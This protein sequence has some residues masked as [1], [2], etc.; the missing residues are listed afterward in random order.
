MVTVSRIVYKQY[1]CF[2]NDYTQNF[3]ILENPKV[4]KQ[5]KNVVKNGV[6]LRIPNDK[7]KRVKWHTFPALTNP[8]TKL[9]ALMTAQS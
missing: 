5:S 2:Q 3:L 9:L 8:D 1:S 6:K 4:S 7:I